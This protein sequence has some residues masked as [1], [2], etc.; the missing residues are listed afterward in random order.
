MARKRN[1]NADSH[2]LT[3]G[4]I[5]GFLTFMGFLPGAAVS[6][7]VTGSMV[8]ND[9][10]KANKQEACK[11]D[12]EAHQKR[13]EK[14]RE[15]AEKEFK[16]MEIVVYD[17]RFF[18]PDCERYIEQEKVENIFI[19]ANVID[20]IDSCG[21]VY[22]GKKIPLSDM[23]KIATQTEP[24]N[25]YVVVGNYLKK[26]APE[27]FIVKTEKE[28]V[29]IEGYFTTYNLRNICKK[30]NIPFRKLS[31]SEAGQI[32]TELIKKLL[33]PFNFNFSKYR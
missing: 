23:I 24:Q 17:M 8:H 26:F 15:E 14:A 29:Y 1:V 16:K 33:E 21:L 32:R 31:H 2:L 22:K 27:Y 4:L 20:V 9:I 18:D 3:G 6:A 10:K 19:G 7:A 28:I 11:R 25:K 30:Y 5:T 13:T 12:F